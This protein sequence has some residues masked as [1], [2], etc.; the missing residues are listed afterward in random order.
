MK[1]AYVY[2]AIVVLLVAVFGAFI[3]GKH[4]AGTQ[5]VMSQ[6]VTTTGADT[7]GTVSNTIAT[8]GAA[9]TA[10]K[11]GANGMRVVF[12]LSD[13]AHSLSSLQAV[14]LTASSVAVYSPTTGWVTVTPGQTTFALL[15]QS[16][17]DAAKLF[18]DAGLVP[19]TYT[20]LRFTIGG[21]TVEEKNGLPSTEARIPSMQMLLPIS[22]VVAKGQ[23]SGVAIDLNSSKSLFKTSGG[24]YVYF[25]VV[26]VTTHH[27][28]DKVQTLGGN[29]VLLGG[30][31]DFSKTWGMDA[32]GLLT[33]G[34]SYPMYLN[35]TQFDL[36]GKTIEQI[37]LGG[38]N[39]ASITPQ[40]AISTAL[41]GGHF[42]AAA[43]IQLL[44]RQNVLVWE[45]DGFKSGTLVQA[46]ID[47][48]TGKLV[49]VE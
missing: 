49:A 39:A 46:Y 41:Q 1:P 35:T 37:P 4:S 24:S 36:V 14:T 25:P 16:K 32:N 19:G 9:A 44:T 42:T 29:T 45:V 40:A 10:P 38:I 43:S 34:F 47:A 6:N 8:P 33:A 21:L 26:T 31:T 3:A 28:L 18:A 11:P 5:S 22:L 12:T 15:D 48:K 30:Y 7:T 2:I 13:N 17:I 20:S 23:T 27:R